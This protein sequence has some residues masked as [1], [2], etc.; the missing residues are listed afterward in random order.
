M[1]ELS[2]WKINVELAVDA[3]TYT[4]G[5]LSAV[6]AL[7]II[8][9]IWA[10]DRQPKLFTKLVLVLSCV[11]F[12]SAITVFIQPRPD[13]IARMEQTGM[14]SDLCYIQI[15]AQSTLY[16]STI[17]WT[18][19]LSGTLLAMITYRVRSDVVQRHLWWV[20]TLCVLVPVALTVMPV[21]YPGAY[22][23]SGAWCGVTNKYPLL[24][25]GRT[26]FLMWTAL[27]FT[28]YVFISVS[29]SIR[30]RVEEDDSLVSV[31]TRAIAGK[32]RWFP[33]VFALLCA[34]AS[35]NRVYMTITGD[36][37]LFGLFVAHKTCAYL[38]GFANAIVFGSSTGAGRQM[39]SAIAS[40]LRRSP[41][42]DSLDMVARAASHGLDSE[43]EARTGDAEQT[44]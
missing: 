28:T 14:V 33:L 19:A 15:Y 3:A 18:M 39:I 23:V 38:Q 4:A 26:Y 41:S 37:E 36:S 32:L 24:R 2:Q 16:L 44:V 1:P 22:G 6:G 42:N 30:A 21:A 34:P 7:F 43:C 27:V 35:V 10:Y 9:C 40:R 5:G 11:D 12:L 8:G 31:D 17:M 29:R 20:S 13:S 25:L